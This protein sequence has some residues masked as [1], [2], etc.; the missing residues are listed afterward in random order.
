M[1]HL[2]LIPTVGMAM[3]PG[4]GTPGAVMVAGRMGMAASKLAQ[5]MPKFMAGPMGKAAGT[6]ATTGAVAGAGS[7]TEGER[8]MGAVE[9]G[10]T[11]A[12]LGPMVAKGIQLGG[13]GVSAIKNA[14]Q[15]SSQVL[16]RMMNDESMIKY[17]S[18]RMLK[19]K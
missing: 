5:Y 19:M 12:V 14:I 7:A 10:A 3:I 15:T 13:Q 18:S 9:G 17:V 8:G 11:G 1:N 4:A 6:A 2:L 16:R